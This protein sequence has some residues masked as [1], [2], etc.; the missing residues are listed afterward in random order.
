MTPAIQTA[1][2]N[3]ER[4]MPALRTAKET[5]GTYDSWRL[6]SGRKGLVLNKWL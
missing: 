6:N 1:D 3:F 5:F 2:K 4:M